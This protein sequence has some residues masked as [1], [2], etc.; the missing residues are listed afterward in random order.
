MIRH[1]LDTI[2]KL[3]DGDLRC[4]RTVILN[5]FK[6]PLL[7]FLSVQRQMTTIFEMLGTWVFILGKMFLDLSFPLTARH[8]ENYIFLFLAASFGLKINPVY[9]Q[10]Q[11]NVY[12]D[13]FVILFFALC[14][15]R[16]DDG[17]VKLQQ[18]SSPFRSFRSDFCFQLTIKRS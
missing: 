17:A 10:R 13:E 11:R 14:K 6:G 12:R 2:R 5:D 18:I 3:Q 16:D 8:D 7:K 9:Q 15:V 4:S 1:S